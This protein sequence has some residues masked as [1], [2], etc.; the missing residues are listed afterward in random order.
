[1]RVPSYLFRVL[2]HFT[3]LY[4]PVAQTPAA[5]T[6]I[7]FFPSK[8]ILGVFPPGSAQKRLRMVPYYP[9]RHRTWAFP[10]TTPPPPEVS[11]AI[12]LLS[13]YTWPE[14]S[15][16]GYPQGSHGRGRQSLRAQMVVIPGGQSG[17]AI[18]ERSSLEL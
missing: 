11:R 1:M 8:A 13:V 15:R 18:K 12:L 16:G 4:L 2:A 17:A 9:A 5:L 14:L 6:P 3:K 7:S 10:S